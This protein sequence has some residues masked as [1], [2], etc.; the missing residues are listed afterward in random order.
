MLLP[1]LEQSHII[2]KG[3]VAKDLDFSFMCVVQCVEAVEG[4]KS[5]SFRLIT[6]IEIKNDGGNLML[7]RKLNR[8]YNNI[9]LQ[10][11]DIK[12]EYQEEIK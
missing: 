11:Y 4:E 7:W 10:E 12:E 5:L 6:P 1:Y 2:C 8:C 9:I 3:R